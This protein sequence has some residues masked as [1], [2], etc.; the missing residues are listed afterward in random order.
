MMEGEKLMENWILNPIK[1]S[2]GPQEAD[3]GDG[4]CGTYYPY[5]LMDGPNICIIHIY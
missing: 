3:V 2:P 4:G 1:S 5:C